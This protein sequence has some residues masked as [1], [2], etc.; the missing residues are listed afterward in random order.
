MGKGEGVRGA[1]RAEGVVVAVNK[2]L[3]LP[4]R[5]LNYWQEEVWVSVCVRAPVWGLRGRGWGKGTKPAGAVNFSLLSTPPTLWVRKA[6]ARSASSRLDSAIS[7]VVG[8]GD[9][10]VA[11]PTMGAPRRTGHRVA[12]VA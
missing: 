7:G 1:G 2:V 4:K 8:P 5:S 12:I 11:V 10:K 3:P 9:G 6:N